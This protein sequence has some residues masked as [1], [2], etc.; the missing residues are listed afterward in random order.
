[1][2]DLTTSPELPG[3]QVIRTPRL[4]L[5]LLHTETLAALLAH[6]LDRASYLQGL[7]LPED[8]FSFDGGDDPFFRVQ[9]ERH[10]SHPDGRSWCAR[11]MVGEQ[12]E[13]LGHCGFHGPPEAVGRAEIGYTVMPAHR[14]KG[15][16]SEAAM[17]LVGWAWQQGEETVYASVSPHNAASLAVVRKLG[18]VQTGVQ[19]DEIDGE[20][21]VFQIWRAGKPVP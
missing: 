19:M 1:M 16:A 5:V 17:A 11:V 12:D 2:G 15:Y 6:D 20:E 9:L 18:F 8:S 7:D 21:L 3:D 13:V 4:S 14:G 10:R